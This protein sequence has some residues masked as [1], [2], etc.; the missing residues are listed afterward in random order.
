MTSELI[1]HINTNLVDV[2]NSAVKAG[3]KVVVAFEHSPAGEA[4]VVFRPA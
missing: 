4:I 3:M 2:D 1:R